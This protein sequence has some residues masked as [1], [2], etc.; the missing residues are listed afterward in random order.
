[1]G[2]LP[3]VPFTGSLH[4][5]DLTRTNDFDDVLPNSD[6]SMRAE[7]NPHNKEF[8]AMQMQNESIVSTSL[9]VEPN[10]GPVPSINET[11]LPPIFPGVTV[12]QD[13]LP[14]PVNN[15]VVCED[16]PVSSDAD[17]VH[18]LYPLP[19]TGEMDDFWQIPFMVR[20]IGVYDLA[21]KTYSSIEQPVLV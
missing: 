2:S 3:P 21:S 10:L 20:I 1:M 9:A 8:P 7:E 14:M 12:F 15:N 11:G 18:E 6:V 17:H 4:D 19:E 16:H 13:P 5:T